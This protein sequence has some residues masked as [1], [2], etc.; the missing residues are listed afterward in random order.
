MARGLEYN[1]KSIGIM[2]KFV[3]MQIYKC[4]SCVECAPFAR[5]VHVRGFLQ[6]SV[7]V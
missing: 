4:Y 3:R 2:H 1:L 7:S 5:K 6:V